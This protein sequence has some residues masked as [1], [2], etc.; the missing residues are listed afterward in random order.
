M[1]GLAEGEVRGKLFFQYLFELLDAANAAMLDV[2]LEV[3]REP[4][5]YVPVDHVHDSPEFVHR[6]ALDTDN[7]HIRRGRRFHALHIPS[8]PVS[9]NRLTKTAFQF[10]TVEAA[11]CFSGGE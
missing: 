1:N 9:S 10:F 4:A 6:A 8:C 11:L 3:T 2:D 7:L 5:V